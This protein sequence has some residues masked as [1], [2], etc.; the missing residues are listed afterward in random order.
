MKLLPSVVSPLMATKQSPYFTLRESYWTPEMVR[1]PLRTAEASA[2]PE[3]RSEKI[4]VVIIVEQL[5]STDNAH[6]LW[7]L[8]LQSR[9]TGS[10][11]AR[12]LVEARASFGRPRLHREGGPAALGFGP[13]R[14]TATVPLAHP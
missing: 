2:T 3:S 1:S 8:L 10:G 14:S 7:I 5:F 6:A 9:S 4:I 12:S 13:T 11:R